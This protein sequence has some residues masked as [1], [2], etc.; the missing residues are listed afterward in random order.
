MTE[1]VDPEKK[2]DGVEVSADKAIEVEL[3]LIRD[4][5]TRRMEFNRRIQ[6]FQITL[7]G[8][9]LATY[10]T[11]LADITHTI[12]DAA[13][14]AVVTVNSIFLLEI[15]QNNYYNLLAALYIRNVLSKKYKTKN[16]RVIIEW[17]SFLNEQRFGGRS[18]FE[19]RS[20]VLDGHLLMSLYLLLFPTLAYI[21]S[22]VRAGA[23][24]PDYLMMPI[25]LFGVAI[26][27]ITVSRYIQDGRLIVADVKS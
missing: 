10:G 5:I 26:S 27:S 8:L 24:G 11:K 19:K 16:N 21:T 1:E 13:C 25:L 7:V 14:V 20:F 22:V 17:E 3:N 2:T 23:S 4:E 6:N 18:V 12:F 9:I 15:R